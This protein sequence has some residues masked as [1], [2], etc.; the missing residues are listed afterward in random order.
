MNQIVLHPNVW[1]DPEAIT[2]VE[3]IDITDEEVDPELVHT[4][5]LSPVIEPE[6]NP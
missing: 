2:I 1:D 6:R 5:V 4:C 3:E